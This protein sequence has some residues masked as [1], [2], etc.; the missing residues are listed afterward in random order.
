MK[1]EAGK[2]NR[3]SSTPALAGHRTGCPFKSSSASTTHHPWATGGRCRT[4]R[5]F[6]FSLIFNKRCSASDT[7]L[8]IC[9]KCIQNK[10]YFLLVQAY[11]SSAVVSHNSSLFL[12]AWHL[13]SLTQI[14]GSR[15]FFSGCGMPSGLLLRASSLYFPH[16]LHTRR[17]CRS[18]AAVGQRWKISS[19]Y[20]A[21]TICWAFWQ[22]A[23]C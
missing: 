11:C 9:R 19:F 13:L 2:N 20:P 8:V 22:Q 23:S 4:L 17:Q 1:S 12:G 6:Y 10:R 16:T 5:T 3:S 21:T 18:S 7:V 15:C 14:R